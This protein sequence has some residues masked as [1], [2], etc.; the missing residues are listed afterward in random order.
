MHARVA[1]GENELPTGEWDWENGSGNENSRL[2][3]GVG[4]GQWS[5][6]ASAG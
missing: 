6:G 3:S 5:A 1:L 2:V 4:A